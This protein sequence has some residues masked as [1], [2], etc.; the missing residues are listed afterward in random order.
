MNHKAFTLIGCILAT[1]LFIISC[2]S[3]TA[4]PQ[5]VTHT[6]HNSTGTW[7]EIKESS[8]KQ[9]NTYSLCYLA[10]SPTKCYRCSR[11]APAV[12]TKS[13]LPLK[14]TLF[15]PFSIGLK[16]IAISRG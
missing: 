7:Y 3:T 9:D 16:A 5:K 8:L 2:T 14:V 6:G 10:N 13:G 11:T 4:E 1:V 15:K 12:A